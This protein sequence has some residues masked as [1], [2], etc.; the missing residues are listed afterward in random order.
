MSYCSCQLTWENI[1]SV[2]LGDKLINVNLGSYAS[3]K[4]KHPFYWL[5]CCFLSFTITMS[6]TESI[7]AAA[8]LVP[9]EPTFVWLKR[10]FGSRYWKHAYHERNMPAFLLGQQVISSSWVKWERQG[11]YGGLHHDLGCGV[12]CDIQN[13]SCCSGSPS[14]W[15][16]PFASVF[17]MGNGW[18]SVGLLCNKN[19]LFP[20]SQVQS[21]IHEFISSFQ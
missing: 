14:S 16:S 19:S 7:A 4:T 18:K 5:T 21:W 12:W 10:V 13:M 9:A 20:M 8:C 6:C 2:K 11:V 1:I 17:H 15:A 3:W